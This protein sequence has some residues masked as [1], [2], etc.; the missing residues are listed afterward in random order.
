[1]KEIYEEDYEKQLDN[2]FI[3]YKEFTYD[4]MHYNAELL[5]L[6]KNM[7]ITQHH[8]KKLILFCKN[9]RF[10]NIDEH[11]SLFF[12]ISM[13]PDQ[14]DIIDF[15]TMYNR[16]YELIK[17]YTD[18]CLYMK[19][20]ENNIDVICHRIRYDTFDFTKNYDHLNIN[21]NDS[22]KIKKSIFEN[23]HNINLAKIKKFEKIFHIV[24]DSDCVGYMID[25]Y[26]IERNTM[27]FDSI[28][29]ICKYFVRNN[30]NFD[31]HARKKL[32]ELFNHKFYTLI[33][34]KST[35]LR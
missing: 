7:K 30:M 16:A 35:K 14:N 29:S 17:Q 27:Y 18:Y 20:D 9:K 6:L 3:N 13:F 8:F 28:Y 2:I 26:Y 34:D 19:L 25:A 33:N 4:N 24:Y 5:N 21:N 32:Y 31:C 11:F 22:I 15:L 12:E 1:M 23:M 10:I